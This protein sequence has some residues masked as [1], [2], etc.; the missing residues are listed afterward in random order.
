MIPSTG[1][2]ELRSMKRTA[3]LINTAR[4]PI[5]DEAELVRAL[6]EG[7]IAGAGVSATQLY[8]KIAR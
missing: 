4:G 6:Q 2:A 1:A 5:I 3:F 7:V 8:F